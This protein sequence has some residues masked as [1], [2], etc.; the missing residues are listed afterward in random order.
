[1]FMQ[2][3]PLLNAQSG[4]GLHPGEIPDRIDKGASKPCAGL[5]REQ[6]QLKDHANGGANEKG[7]DAFEKDLG[8]VA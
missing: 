6:H 4:G 5:D 7:A 3:L 2:V 8:A 1:M